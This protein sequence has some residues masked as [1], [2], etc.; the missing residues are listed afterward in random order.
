MPT[1]PIGVCVE[2]PAHESF[3]SVCS[4]GFITS[5]VEPIENATVA[6]AS[7]ID[8]IIYDLNDQADLAAAAAMLKI[9]ALYNLSP[10]ALPGI[11]YQAPTWVTP[12]LYG[13]NPG[14]ISTTAAPPV[15]NNVTWTPTTLNDVDQPANN[16]SEPTTTLPDMPDAP[17]LT[18]SPSAPPNSPTA[19]IPGIVEAPAYIAPTLTLGT[20]DT[21]VLEEINITIPD[22][23]VFDPLAFTIDFSAIDEA[24]DRANNI[25]IPTAEIPD[26]E[27]L[28]PEV[29]TV[30][31]SMVSGIGPVDDDRV[32]LDDVQGRKVAP[33]L[34]RRG[35][36]VPVRIP[37]FDSWLQ[38]T[39]DE[40]SADSATLFSAEYHDDV[41]NAAFSLAAEAEDILVKI[42]LG[43]YDARFEYSLEKARAQ[44]LRAKSIVASYN[45]Q[46]LKFS[47]YTLEYNAALIALRAQA[48]AVMTQAEI[49]ELIGGANKLIARQFTIEEDIKQSDVKVFR[50]EVSGEAAKLTAHKAQIDVIDAKL[51][52]AQAAMLTYNGE[53]VKFEAEVQKV[54]NVFDSYIAGSRAVTEENQATRA[55]IRGGAASIKALASQA[56]ASAAASAAEAIRK[57]RVSKSDEASLVSTNATNDIAKYSIASTQAE[58]SQSTDQLR[59]DAVVDSV[60]PSAVADMGRAIS[61]FTRIALESSGRAASMAQRAN[62]SLVRAYAAAYDAAGRAGAAVASG[63]LSGFRAS[64]SLTAAG[65]I[66]AS[67]GKSEAY[68]SSGATNYS[69]RDTANQSIT[70]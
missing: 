12:P 15:S 69:E 44:L 14:N 34:A 60:Q 41:I 48:E 37:D 52:E 23:V 13:V 67:R 35:R 6:A 7:D 66:D 2:T 51:A 9:E 59:V 70:V 18:G 1:T 45:A 10:P 27:Q 56:G 49:A 11:S 38:T 16:I 36:E 31:G 61:R 47:A 43:L 28:I 63:K 5:P 29:F 62:E 26:Y 55:E 20:V 53:T 4:G 17:P 68:T 25:A 58:Y 19:Y 30:V 40:Y 42:D 21:P 3:T 39:M 24:I 54:R 33:M 46:I 57:V 8:S 64:A 22:M 65:S 32:L 50:A